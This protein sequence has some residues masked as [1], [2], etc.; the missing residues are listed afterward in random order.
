MRN[1][2]DSVGAAA[3]AEIKGRPGDRIDRSDDPPGFW[4]RQ[5][6]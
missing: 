3:L 1:I 2:L 5:R 6:L 4:S